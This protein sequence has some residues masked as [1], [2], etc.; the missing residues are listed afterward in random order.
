MSLLTGRESST[1]YEFLDEFGVTELSPHTSAPW[2]LSDFDETL[3]SIY[4]NKKKLYE[5]DWSVRL[6]DG[7]LLTDDNNE[8]LLRSLKHL[9]I[10]GTT[11]VNDE[12]ATLAPASLKTRLSFI[13]KIID[14]L[15]IH[16]QSLSLI[17]FGLGALNADELKGILNHLA[18]SPRA[19]E[20]VYA[21]HERASA[22]CNAQLS[23]II[24]S[25]AEDF[26]AKYPSML[27]VNDDE[28]EDLKLNITV[29]EIPMIRAALMKANL[30]YGTHC[31]GFKVNTKLLSESVYPDTIYGRQTPKS[32][33][34]VLSFYPSETRY[35]R[36]Y[37]KV[38]V[39]T[40]ES[41]HLIDTAYFYYR[42]ALVNS[43]ALSTLGL[44]APSDTHTII[45]YIPKLNEASRYRS[46][47]ASN[48]LKLFRCSIDFH[49]EHGRKVLN[50]FIRVAAHCHRQNLAM[51]RL[52]EADFLR[53]IG[54]EL[55]SFGV[56]K[57]GLSSYRSN[58]SPRKGGAKQYFQHLRANHGLLELVSVYLGSV[59][60]AVGMLMARRI[61][62]LVTLDASRCLDESKSW[63]VFNLAKSTHKA[64]GIRQRESRP[65][66]AIAVEMIEELRRFQMILKRLGV[67]S[68]LTNLFATPWLRGLKGLQDCTLHLYHRN[69]DLACDY[70]ESDINAAGE[71][72]YVRQHQL[73][74]FFAIMFFYTNSFGEL[75]T[76][77][78]M[79]GHRDIEHV[80]HY[81]TE[82]LEP[83]DIRGAGARYFAELAKQ[84]RLENYQNL[85]DL[86]FAEFGTSKF[87][88]V[89]EQ[90]IEDYLSAM[91]EEGKVRIEPQ[92]F[93]DENGKSMKVLFIVS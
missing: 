21:W 48:L 27:E 66:D 43:A 56:K 11:G 45:E 36:E 53:I 6:G 22:F 55:V 67:I 38:K 77:R 32:S 46:V 74:R 65:I 63:L 84:E 81:L 34:E 12:F 26:F 33:L 47:P 8:V 7:S 19:E 54:P 5:L 50:G 75:D 83:K 68:D 35:K 24:Y 52:P 72:Y 93:N 51:T 70:F 29:A 76:L 71:R 41:E 10:I 25:E 89:D 57:L 3:W 86:L 59:Q 60:L 42:Y 79:L 90:K 1:G 14:Y 15:L 37:P 88:L 13:L 4:I 17:Q 20:S 9:L 39:T 87:S 61:D 85:Q 73:R 16:A 44:P 92:F 2:L 64:L 78:W 82:C 58:K 18:S 91:L 49:V 62:E 69:L 80:W 31:Q 30:Y 23:N 40:G 28:C